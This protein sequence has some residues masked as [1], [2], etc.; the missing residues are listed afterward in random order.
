MTP[1]IERIPFQKYGDDGLLDKRE[2]QRVLCLV[3]DEGVE[4]GILMWRVASGYTAEICK[5]YLYREE[6]RRQ[7]WGTLLLN[8]AF[9]DMRHTMRHNRNN[10]D[11]LRLVWLLAE[12][13]NKVGRAFYESRGFEEQID[14]PAF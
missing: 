13:S 2:G 6:D 3:D 5:F 11:P 12:R 9:E 10:Q 14:L 4:R 7:G 1:R 8:E